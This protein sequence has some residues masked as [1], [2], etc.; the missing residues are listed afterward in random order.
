M[1]LSVGKKIGGAFFTLL[2]LLSIITFLSIKVT[3]ATQAELQLLNTSSQHLSLDYQIQNSFQGVALALRGYATYGDPAFLQQYRDQVAHTQELIRQRIQNA[4]PETKP[5]LEKL[6]SDFTSYEQQL[7]G[8]MIPLLQAN[9][10]EEALQLGHTLTPLT[11]S[12]NQTLQQMIQQNQAKNNAAIDETVSQ[13]AQGR[14]WVTVFSGLALLLG[15]VLSVIITRSITT[16]L[17]TIN[18][19]VKVLAEGDFTREVA[20]S[21]GDEIGQLAAAV[22][23]TRE[24]LKNLVSEITEIAQTVAAQSQQLAASAEEVSGTAE[25][26]AGTTNQVA[27]MAEKSLANA[28]TTVAESHKVL[29]VAAAGG[30]TVRRTVEKI[31]AIARSVEAVHQSVQSLG[32]LSEKIGS[33]TALITGIAD[34]TNLLA[35]NAAI[36]AARAGEQGRGFA[37][38]AEEVRK[39]AEQSATA[40]REIGQLVVQIQSGIGVAAQAMAQGTADVQEGVNLASEAG[41]ALDNIMQAVTGNIEL[42]EEIAQGAGQTSEGTQQLSASNQQ[43]TST[44]QQVAGATQELANIAGKLQSS[45]EKFKI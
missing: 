11:A 45:V 3:S 35:L 22:N 26:V 1:K 19:G 14:Q 9:K 41:Q 36:E 39:L 28:R 15:I 29:E 5:K 13:A 12:I 20:V 33:I 4:A 31:N 8:R 16:P 40:A 27:A 32:Q 30:T 34:Q 7:S 21:A 18:Q 24:Q 10:K 42:V 23:S 37:V 38:V 17:Q 44:I 43:V 25:E 2:A 6:L